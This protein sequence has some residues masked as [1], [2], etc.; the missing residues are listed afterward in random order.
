MQLGAH[1]DTWEPLDDGDDVPCFDRPQGGVGTHLTV[2]FTGFP[3]EQSGFSLL[4]FDAVADK[5]AGAPDPV[6]SAYRT[7]AFPLDCQPDGSLLLVDVPI[8][9]AV[10]VESADTI[11]GVAVHVR[12]TLDLADGTSLSSDVDVVLRESEFIPPAWWEQ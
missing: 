2:R 7:R 9:F 6:I 11:E 12:T 1:G 5:D 4:S 3:E 10:G 8:R